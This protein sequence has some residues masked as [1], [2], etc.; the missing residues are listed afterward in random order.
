MR[1]LARSSSVGT[2]LNRWVASATALDD[3]AK[4][5]AAVA[6]LPFKNDRRSKARSQLKAEYSECVLMVHT[7]LP[8][9]FFIVALARVSKLKFHNS[10]VSLQAASARLSTLS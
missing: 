5:H 2:G 4:A 7:L 3:D 6:P 9:I 10:S 8:I 1:S